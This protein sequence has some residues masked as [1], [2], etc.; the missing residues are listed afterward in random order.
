[1]TYDNE[2][3]FGYDQLFFNIDTDYSEFNQIDVYNFET[4]PKKINEI[5][6]LLQDKME[7]LEDKNCKKNQ[8]SS[9][10]ESFEGKAENNIESY[11]N[12]LKDLNYK[13]DILSVIIILLIVFIIIQCNSISTMGYFMQMSNI[14]HLKIHTP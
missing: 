11:I 10:V 6:K 1:M 4:P 3:N 9:K 12:L 7:E 8:V 2:V 14:N 5:D 13:N